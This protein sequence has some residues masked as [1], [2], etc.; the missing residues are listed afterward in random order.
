[1]PPHSGG[2]LKARVFFDAFAECLVNVAL[3]R[4]S[5]QHLDYLRLTSIGTMI[6]LHGR[7]VAEDTGRLFDRMWS[8]S[9]KPPPR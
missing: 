9:Q 6:V 5:P 7:S 1:M 8:D 3:A 4:K 2:A